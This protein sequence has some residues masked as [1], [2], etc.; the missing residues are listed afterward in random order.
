MS[1][2]EYICDN[3]GSTRAFVNRDLLVADPVSLG[4]NK[5]PQLL[6]SNPTLLASNHARI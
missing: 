4:G 6:A 1:T 2:K 3:E 5:D